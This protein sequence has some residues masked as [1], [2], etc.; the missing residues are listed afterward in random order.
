MDNAHL[1]ISSQ[2]E[3][4]ST[5]VPAA[6][7]DELPDDLHTGLA[8][9]NLVCEHLPRRVVDHLSFAL[10][11]G[12]I[13]CLLG[14]SGCGK[15]TTLRAIAGLQNLAAGHISINGA[16]VSTPTRALVPEKRGL[17]MVF[18]E[19]AL[20]PHM[21]VA[22]NIGFGVRASNIPQDYQ[23][24]RSNVKRYRANRVAE[25]IE[26][27]GLQGLEQRYPEELSGGQQQRVALARALAPKPKLLLLDEPFS[28]LDVELRERL[29]NEVHDI[30]KAEGVTALL[31]THEQLEAFAMADKLGVMHE[32]KIVQW[33]TPYNVYHQP[34]TRFV[35]DFIGQGRFIRG[36]V[37]TAN[38]I[39]TTIGLL[40]SRHV[41]AAK[42]G[43]DVDVLL[44]PDDIIFDGPVSPDSLGSPDALM[45][46]VI[47]RAFKG[48]EILYTLQLETGDR[49]LSLFPSHE[50]Y[51]EGSQVRVR[52]DTEH[53]IA[54]PA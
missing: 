5:E 48:A 7:S 39:D 33:D 22:K 36:Q 6:L 51:A 4:E 17:G 16:V 45:A 49:V 46:T 25:M 26:L 15:T 9:R 44:R 40:K 20:F 30:L 8:V 23:G 18:Q 52:T 31:V 38:E 27:T 11:P 1:T 35:A 13:G 43:E 50:N 29:S 28:N 32:G 34:A 3:A 19:Y 41:L 14:Q 53:V 10:Q 37:N 47:K 24:G 54:F 12:E 2:I 21:T 42:P